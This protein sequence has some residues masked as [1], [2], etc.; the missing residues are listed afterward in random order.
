MKNI[1][2]TVIFPILGGNSEF[3]KEK[4]KNAVSD[5]HKK[6]PEGQDPKITRIKLE[7][8]EGYAAKV[9]KKN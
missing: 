3:S 1:T 2:K 7:K 9:S 8:G 5:G 4:A 6:C